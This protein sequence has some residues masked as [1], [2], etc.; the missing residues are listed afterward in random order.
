MDEKNERLR[1]GLA[2]IV[3]LALLAVPSMGDQKV[4]LFN[5]FT[6]QSKSVVAAD[7]TPSVVL[8]DLMLLAG[9]TGA[10]LADGELRPTVSLRGQNIRIPQRPNLRSAFSRFPPFD[11]SIW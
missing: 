5:P 10:T 9:N 6:L 4:N 3:L 11:A 2:L 8:N 1:L 7:S